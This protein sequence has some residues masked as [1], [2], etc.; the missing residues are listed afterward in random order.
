MRK[1]YRR[2]VLILLLTPFLLWLAVTAYN[3]L[4]ASNNAWRVH[5]FAGE[6]AF[7][8]Y[9]FKTATNEFRLAL[10]E[11]KKFGGNDL[12]V[13]ES[14]QWL[15]DAYLANFHPDRTI[16]LY[17][18]LRRWISQRLG[19]PQDFTPQ[20]KR[21]LAKS[22]YERALAI[23][24]KEYGANDLRL[25]EFLHHY[26]ENYYVYFD[27]SYNGKVE[28]QK[29]LSRA[30]KIVEAVKGADSSEIIPYLETDYAIA[31]EKAP[32]SP[33]VRAL[34]E[35]LYRL[36]FRYFPDNRSAIED[37]FTL[38]TEYLFYQEHDYR[39]CLA[40]YKK[41]LASSEKHLA[42]KHYEQLMI[43]YDIVQNRLPKFA[44]GLPRSEFFLGIDAYNTALASVNRA[45]SQ[46]GRYHP[47]IES[48]K[49]QFAG[50]YST[51]GHFTEAEAMLREI[52]CSTA[53]RC[54][55]GDEAYN[56]TTT[57]TRAYLELYINWGKPEK[58]QAAYRRCRQR[59]SALPVIY[60]DGLTLPASR[61]R[62]AVA[63]RKIKQAELLFM[64]ASV[65]RDGGQTAKAQ[66]LED[67][68]K[69]L[70][71]KYSAAYLALSSP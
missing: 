9:D 41:A 67:E 51:R 57:L 29:L 31:V 11:A 27:D 4:T 23:Y 22:L 40:V 18:T 59:I 20:M 16:T 53:L 26:A 66:K 70:Q 19:H 15:A 58:L 42:N 65:L 38:L 36:K 8:F 17:C 32:V 49:L 2:R 37:S 7:K 25:A 14:S 21:Y 24:E 1:F 44:H 6:F 56:W 10:H 63:F 13:A 45:Y 47:L 55:S 54:P 69:Q 60:P 68:A 33:E 62:F 46:T 3:R 5:Q 50:Y 64:Y 71:K 43:W 28:A 30:I 35:K 48:V 12:R 61:Q 39:E 34:L 52:E